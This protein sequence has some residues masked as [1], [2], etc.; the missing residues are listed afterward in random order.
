MLKDPLYNLVAKLTAAIL[1]IIVLCH[2]VHGYGLLVPAVLG[3]FYALKGNAGVSL[4]VYVCLPVFAMLSPLLFQRG[5][6]F[7]MISRLTSLALAGALVLGG[8]KR[9][10]EEKLPLGYIF[11]YLVIALISSIQGWFPLISYFKL[12]NFVAFFMGLYIGTK[13]I[14]Q[15]KEDVLLVRSGILAIA[16]IIIWGSLASLAY[17]PMAYLT[18]LRN[19]INSDGLEVAA[20]VASESD[21]KGLFTGVT[22]QS[23]FLGP[24]LACL[25]GWIACDMLFIERRIRLL[26]LLLLAPT[27]VMLAMTRSRTGMLTFCLLLAVLMFYCLPRIQLPEKERNKVKGLIFS[28]AF[29]IVALAVLLEAR[30]GTV[31]RLI[32]KSND[33]EDDQRTLVEAF[34][35]SRQGKIEECMRDFHLNP[36][37]GKGFQVIPEHVELFRTGQISI[38]S[39]S[40]EK[41]ILPL[42][43]LGETGIIGA[44]AFVFFL[45]MF[46]SEASKKKYIATITLFC[47]LLTSNLSEAT[48]F[49]PGG[50]GG[51]FWML[52]V[53]GGFIIDMNLKTANE[54]SAALGTA[55]VN[56]SRRTRL[57]SDQIRAEKAKQKTKRGNIKFSKRIMFR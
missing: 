53:G 13:N 55:P 4:L 22:G 43:V 50:A 17:P 6:A 9:H 41:G 27:P 12:L 25:A 26:H 24:C 46:F 23:Q 39:A 19:V 2:F 18:S 31:S 47:A 20:E 38:F 14:N 44:I 30:N 48:F 37:W 21:Y 16:V 3:L 56:P 32:R 35:G 5:T 29:I 33:L 1:A 10:G 36:L 7:A 54:E 45:Y 40:I 49:S 51:V 8:A 42:M 34:T 52:T 57:S 28:F 11:F 15:K